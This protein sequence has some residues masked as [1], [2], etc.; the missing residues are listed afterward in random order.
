MFNNDK[1]G[2]M[3]LPVESGHEE[4][5]LDLYK[6]WNADALRDS[7]GTTM[8]RELENLGSEVYSTICVVRAQQ[9]FADAHPEYLHRKYLMSHP[10]TA[11]E[12]KLTINLLDGYSKD[13]YEVDTNSDPKLWFE[14]RNRTNSSI[15]NIA[16]WEID[17]E[18]GVA[19][20]NNAIP[21]NE[22]TVSFLARQVWD[23]VSMYNHLT[24]GWT[25]RKIKSLDPYH[26]ECRE[27][28]VSWF[29]KWII[30]HPKT[31]V[32]R[33]TTFAFNFVIDSGENN[34]DIYRDWLGY[35][36]TVS[37]EALIDFEKKYGYKMTPEDFVD[38]GYY[39]ATYKNPS[40]KYLDWMDFIRDF[41]VGFSSELVEI[42]HK[43]GKRAAMFQGDHWIGTEPFSKKYEQIGI[44][45][46]IG[47][48][49]DGVAL[50]R[51]SDSPGEMIREARFYP[52]FFPDVFKE[53][54]NPE[55]GSMD[56]WV[57]IRRALLRSNIHRIGYG[58]YLS[59]ANKFPNFIE[60]VSDLSSQFNLYLENT[61]GTKSKTVGRKVAILNS[62]G[63]LRSWLQNAV[64]DQRFHIPSRPDIMEFV[65]SN[66]MECLSGLP[67]DIEFISFD[68]ILSNGI[69]SDIGVIINMG[70]S[71]TSWTGHEQWGNPEVISTLREFVSNGGG[72]LGI[73]EPSSY[74]KD[75][76]FFQLG[77]ILGLEKETGLTMGRVAMPLKIDESHILYQSLTGLEDF[78]K[79]QDVY[80]IDEKISI[81]KSN[82]QQINLCVNSYGTGRSSYISN[83]PFTLENSRFLENLILW[84]N[85]SDSKLTPY[86]S[87]NPY[88]DVAFYPETSMLAL[89]NS[90]NKEQSVK[91]YT[92]RDG[93][94][95]R[96][97]KA[98]SWDW[99]KV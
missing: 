79:D 32:V 6:K 85:K 82:G 30:E 2:Y 63:S 40:K 19:I 77:D 72:F 75:G 88:V 3:T 33:F 87:D 80:P 1:K 11:T 96:T 83:L 76:R 47:A 45:I 24:N 4:L 71:M 31:T 62:W 52:Y 36:E 37:P 99:E 84:L 46:N 8:S 15:V 73:G 92:E 12:K 42:A 65:G 14:V 43:A 93:Y 25:G 49:E 70:D 39:N 90:T 74:L 34:Q 55:G 54:N 17:T 44:D 29:K 59:L 81:L 21:Y 27:Y 5:V 20:I 9:D 35:G 95:K 94:L 98:Y 60:H 66:P 51:L 48:V 38:N 22:Y 68:D 23:S 10:K 26:K 97:I 56:N 16:N 7:D 78:G 67:F 50:R 57:K 53:G 18:K 86:L 89:V 58:G 61:K 41:V 69:N 28:L 64:K 91:I 13:K